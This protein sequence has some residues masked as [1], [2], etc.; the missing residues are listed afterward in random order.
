M[1][2]NQINTNVGVTGDASV[3]MMN[4]RTLLIWVRVPGLPQ[5]S[6]Q[7]GYRCNTA[8]VGYPIAIEPRQRFAMILRVR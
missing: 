1:T 5:E 3:V 2:C 7:R 8:S 6:H 4:D